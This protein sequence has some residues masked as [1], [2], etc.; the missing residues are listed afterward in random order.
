[1]DGEAIP[2][3]SADVIAEQIGQGFPPVNVEVVHNQ[4]NGAGGGIARGMSAPHIPSLVPLTALAIRKIGHRYNAA[5][6]IPQVWSK[7]FRN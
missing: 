6:A 2:Y 3:L 1:M 7:T 5:R 4:M